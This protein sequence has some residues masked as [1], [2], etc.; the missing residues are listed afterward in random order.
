MNTKDNRMTQIYILTYFLISLIAHFVVTVQMIAFSKE[1]KF[2]IPSYLASIFVS[3]VAASFIAPEAIPGFSQLDP[4]TKGGWYNRI[5]ASSHASTQF[6]VSLYYWLP[7][8]QSNEEDFIVRSSIDIMIAYLIYDTLHEAL[9]TEKSNV[10]TMVHHVL[11]GL[12][13][14]SAWY[15]DCFEVFRLHMLVFLAECTTPF[16]H[17]SWLLI[18]TSM[19]GS[20]LFKLTSYTLV[21]LFFFF[22]FIMS[23]IL[24]YKT[25]SLT[26]NA[27]E[28]Q[29]PYFGMYAFNIFVVGS[30]T[31]LQFVWFHRLVM[32]A[33]G[34]IKLKVQE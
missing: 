20:M 7:A 28:N 21:G 14:V 17:L 19:E 9:F 29:N 34:K 24:L 13:L 25:I 31:L 26:W 27:Y 11:G 12:S 5:A 30:F 8:V 16:L 4:K 23:P 10:E 1:T 6:F 2:L 32:M 22:R 15:Y 18:K 33:I 3:H